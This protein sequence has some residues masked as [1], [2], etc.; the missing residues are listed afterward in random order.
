MFDS[1]L[2]S[3]YLDCLGG[4]GINVMAYDLIDIPI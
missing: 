3:S 4:E 2:L 1:K